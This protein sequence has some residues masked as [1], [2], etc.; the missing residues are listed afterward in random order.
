MSTRLTRLALT[1]GMMLLSACGGRQAP[2]ISGGGTASISVATGA[3]T[4]SVA[5]AAAATA[6]ISIART[7]YSGD[8]A[9]SAEGLPSGI[10]AT[11]APPTLAGSTITSSL[12]LQASGTAAV[13]TSTITV[14][15]RGTGVADAVTTIA[16]T[17]TTAGASA[18]IGLTASPVNADILAGDPASTTVTFTRSGGFTGAVT[19]TVT[20]APAGMTTTFSSANPVTVPSGSLSITT[21]P[22]V[23]PGTYTL[24]L[25]ATSAGITEATATWLVKIAPLPVNAF[26]WR[27]CNPARIPAF[28]AYQNGPEAAWRRATD[29]STGVF[30]FNVDQPQIGIATVATENGLVTTRVQY[31]GL[32]EVAAT[33]AAECAGNPAPGT[34]A[35]T[36]S[37][38]GLSS[39]TEVVTASLGNVVS[40]GASLLNPTFSLAQ[41]LDGPRDLVA[42]LSNVAASTASRLYLRRDVNSATGTSLGALDLFGTHSFAPASAPLT[43][44]APNDGTLLAQTEFTTANGSAATLTSPQ[45]SSGVAATYQGVPEAAMRATDVQLVRVSQ[46][47]TNSSL[48]RSTARYIRGPLALALTM[49]PDPGAPTVTPVTGYAYPRATVSGALPSAYNGRVEFLLQQPARFRAFALAATPAGRG[50][51]TAYS[52]SIP[53]FSALAG[54]QAS[55]ALSSGAATIT[56]SFAGSANAAADGTPIPGTTL[57]SVIRS[58]AF[59]LP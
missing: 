46:S 1:A 40:S 36:G 49:P 18:A 4:L 9:L 31:V 7:I 21:T 53:D 12:T 2:T 26:T 34:K 35:H 48:S 37:V 17:V 33:A 20:G 54:W 52:L 55:W 22:A 32:G 10:T 39:A 29:V 41:V 15:A 58:G 51:S 27:F 56:S 59:T 8:V 25:H 47:V 3:A 38:S 50:S 23:T 13:G 11:F 16:I 30:S 14:R 42:V 57:V 45:L 5:Q 28:F 44:T 19:F 24:T 6:E 43:V